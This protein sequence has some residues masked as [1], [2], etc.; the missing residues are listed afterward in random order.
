M[1]NELAINYDKD[2]GSINRNLAGIL[3]Q[4]PTEIDKCVS[5]SGATLPRRVEGAERLVSMRVVDNDRFGSEVGGTACVVVCNGMQL[6]SPIGIREKIS[7]HL[8]APARAI[9]EWH[10]GI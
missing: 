2:R 5:G 7:E 1:P 3:S 6:E 10:S 4:G 9:V 8:I